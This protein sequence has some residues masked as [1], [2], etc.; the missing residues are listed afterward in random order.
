MPKN[1]DL[2]K[3]TLNLVY[4]DWASLNAMLPPGVEVSVFIRALVHEKVEELRRK[5]NAD[6]SKLKKVEIDL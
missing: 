1:H 6:L 5:G 3:H 4:G 2:Q